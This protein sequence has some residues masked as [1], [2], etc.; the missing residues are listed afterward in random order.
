MQNVPLRSVMPTV[1]LLYKC[2]GFSVSDRTSPHSQGPPCHWESGCFFRSGFTCVESK[3]LPWWSK[4]WECRKEGWGA[5]RPATKGDISAPGQ[6][7][8]EEVTS[9]CGTHPD[10][11]AHLYCEDSSRLWGFTRLAGWGT[12]TFWEATG[13]RN[14][15]V[16]TVTGWT[17]A[18]IFFCKFL[19]SWSCN[20]P[21]F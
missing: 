12:E 17:Q 19:C 13:S 15:Q 10:V 5:Q 7:K 20:L 8:G 16:Y 14:I 18:F 1:S 9:Y 21:P 11:T 4:A 6:G 2:Q 3:G